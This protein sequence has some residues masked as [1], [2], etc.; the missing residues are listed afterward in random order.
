MNSSL[1]KSSDYD[2]VDPVIEMYRS[3]GTGALLKTAKVSV[4]NVCAL[5]Y[6]ARL[7]KLKIDQKS[8]FL[9][10]NILADR[11]RIYSH[12]KFTGVLQSI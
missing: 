6:L 9:I 8:N 5:Q 1:L 11:S 3:S 10:K 4:M 7:I 12:L 2:D